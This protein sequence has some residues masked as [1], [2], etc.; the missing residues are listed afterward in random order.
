MK[1]PYQIWTLKISIRII[2]YRIRIVKDHLAQF[3]QMIKDLANITV[4]KI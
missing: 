2:F 1:F 4:E 3:K